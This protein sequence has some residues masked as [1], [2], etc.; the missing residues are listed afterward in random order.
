MHSFDLANPL[1]PDGF[2]DYLTPVM[3]LTA[4]AGAFNGIAHMTVDERIVKQGAS[5]RRP[6]PHVDGC[7]IPSMMTWGHE[8]GRWNHYCNHLGGEAIQRMS[9]IVAS[10]AAGCKVWRGRFDATPSDSG[11]LS[12]IQDQL[13]EGEVLPPFTGYLLSPDC[14]HESLPMAED[15]AR[16][17]LRIALPGEYGFGGR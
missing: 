9:I 2:V 3:R 15:T 1:M 16:T 14:I 8:G 6:G 10:S 17:F 13:D 7:F 4:L 12:H 5:Q 11:D